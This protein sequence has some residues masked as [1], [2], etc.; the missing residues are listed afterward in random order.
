L[1]KRVRRLTRLNNW[2]TGKH[3]EKAGKNYQSNLSI[4]EKYLT[5]PL[6]FAIY[7]NIADYVKVNSEKYVK[8]LLRQTDSD[9]ILEL[10]R[11]QDAQN[12]AAAKIAV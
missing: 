4:C 6:A 12:R 3:K 9:S 2:D 10:K 7:S 11:I 1:F 8:W 5:A